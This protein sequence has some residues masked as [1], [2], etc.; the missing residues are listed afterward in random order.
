MNSICSSYFSDR[1]SLYSQAVST[2]VLLFV[3]SHETGITG[4]CH[5]ALSLFGI[6]SEELF[7]SNLSPPRSSLLKKLNSSW[8]W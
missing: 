7:A 6:E 1:V 4:I 2:K 3:L 8:T 5:C